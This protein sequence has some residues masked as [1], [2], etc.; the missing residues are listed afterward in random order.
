MSTIGVCHSD[1]SMI[2]GT[3]P[4]PLSHE[5]AGVVEV[6]GE[7]VTH[8]KPGDHVVMSFVPNCGRCYHCLR[9]EAFLCQATPTV[10]SLLPR[11]EVTLDPRHL[12][13][14]VVGLFHWNN[15]EEVGSHLQVRRHP[16]VFDRD[17]QRFLTFFCV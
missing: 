17:A 10:D 15:A 5:G 11:S 6:V 13:G 3:T 4:L 7:G 16:D 9:H 1:L 8:T 12:F 2:N 14:L